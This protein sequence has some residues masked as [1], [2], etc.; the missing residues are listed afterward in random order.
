MA[1]KAIPLEARNCKGC[2]VEFQT[3]D[4]RKWFHKSGCGRSKFEKQT[5]AWLL[6]NRPHFPTEPC[7]ACGA[8]VVQY[9]TR[10]YEGEMRYCKR[11]CQPNPKENYHGPS[12]TELIASKSWLGKC[13]WCNKTLPSGNNSCQACSRKRTLVLLKLRNRMRWLLPKECTDCGLVFSRFDSGWHCNPCKQESR[14]RSRRHSKQL[15]RIRN[16]GSDTYQQGIDY[17][18][19]YVLANGKC[20]LCHEWCDDPSV[21]SRWDGL[22]W[23]P[24]APTVDHVLALANGGTHTWDNVQLACLEC[25]SNKGDRPYTR[26]MHNLPHNDQPVSSDEF[27]NLV[28]GVGRT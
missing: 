3:T 4:P 23:M 20:A 5:N 7:L 12:K 26:A 15:R 22:T 1:Y 10:R 18:S 28:Y 25:N 13:K 8:P 17:Q 27:V 9:R 24:K 14:R 21:W 16:R 2:G 19:L 11:S 6:V